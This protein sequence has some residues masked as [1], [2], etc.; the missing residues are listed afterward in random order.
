MTERIGVCHGSLKWEMSDCR[1]TTGNDS[2]PKRSIRRRPAPTLSIR[3]CCCCCGGLWSTAEDF[4]RRVSDKVTS[5]DVAA[6]LSGSL[7]PITVICWR[8]HSCQSYHHNHHRHQSPAC[9]LQFVDLLGYHLS[10]TITV[11]RI[12][13]RLSDNGISLWHPLFDISSSS[14]TGSVHL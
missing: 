4:A 12:I 9:W 5:P 3:C 7:I 13:H 8:S 10:E 14:S 2:S 1:L 11:H 6:N